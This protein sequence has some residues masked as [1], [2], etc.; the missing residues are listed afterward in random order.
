MPVYSLISKEM[1]DSWLDDLIY[2]FDSL[3]ENPDNGL[4]Y[5]GVL[6]LYEYLQCYAKLEQSEDDKLTDVKVTLRDIKSKVSNTD[7]NHTINRLYTL[8][9]SI[10][11]G[12]SNSVDS[13]M[14]LLS[15]NKFIDF[16]VA[17]ELDAK[18]IESIKVVC[19]IFKNK[20]E[21]Y[22]NCM[23]SCSNAIHNCKNKNITLDYIVTKLCR[24]YPRRFVEEYLIKS[25]ATHTIV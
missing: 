17:F 18:L 4:L 23:K 12:N 6:K 21:L 24:K 25:L 13:I 10:G 11:H 20:D 9:N 5:Y 15:S 7:Y 16:L 19:S 1:L 8:R 2:T 3:Q 14:L 22:N